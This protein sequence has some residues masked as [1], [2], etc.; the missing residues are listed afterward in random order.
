MTRPVD[1]RAP[2][3]NQGVVGA[4]ALAAFLFDAPLLLPFLALALGAGALLGPQA[5]PFALLWRRGVVPLFRLGPPRLLKEAAPVRFAMAV[6]SGFLAVG[7]ILLLAGL[8]PLLGWGLVLAVAALALLAV[9][10]DVCVGCEAYV[11]L[12]RWSARSTRS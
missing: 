7:S 1:P 2:R 9:A 12:Q 5:N 8:V 6:G 11:L 4:G 10:T 3:F